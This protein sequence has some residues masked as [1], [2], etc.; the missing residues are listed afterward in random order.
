M[1]KL[2]TKKPAGDLGNAHGLNIA[3]EVL[4]DFVLQSAN[5]AIDC[6]LAHVRQ[7]CDLFLSQTFDRE[8]CDKPFLIIE[9]FVSFPYYCIGGGAHH[10]SLRG[11]PELWMAAWKL[12]G[13]L[14]PLS[15]QLQVFLAQSAVLSPLPQQLPLLFRA[16]GCKPVPLMKLSCQFAKCFFLLS[17]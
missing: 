1:R 3:V 13:I 4:S 14:E 12:V 8:I 2:I 11:T 6:A 7:A 16:S 10:H 17:G 15:D 5:Y 9:L